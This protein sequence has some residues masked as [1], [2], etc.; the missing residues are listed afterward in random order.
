MCRLVLN[1]HLKMLR[2]HFNIRFK[3]HTFSAGFEATSRYSGLLIL[4]HSPRLLHISRLPGRSPL[5][6]RGTSPPRPVHIGSDGATSDRPRAC[7]PE[8]C[9]I[10]RLGLP[11]SECAYS[12]SNKCCLLGMPL[13]RW[14]LLSGQFSDVLVIAI[15]SVASRCAGSINSRPRAS[16]RSHQPSNLCLTDCTFTA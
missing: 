10:R 8:R 15:A 4:G 6:T 11:S 13:S 5:L 7:W 12:R 3:P 2:T 9:A 1:Q 14:H 16:I